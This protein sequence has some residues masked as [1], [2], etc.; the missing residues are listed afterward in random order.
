MHNFQSHKKISNHLGTDHH[1][2][3]V[4][5]DDMI[6]NIE[7]IYDIYD[8]PFGDSSFLP[9]N[10]VSKL[11]SKSVKVVL[12]GDGGDEIFLGYNR[13][14]FAKKIQKFNNYIPLRI[15]KILKYLLIN[16]SPEVCSVI[17]LIIFIN[18]VFPEPF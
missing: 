16:I 2:I 10:L 9:T 8:E 18:V 3:I 5:I 7:S 4:S 12:S 15:R 1:E 14:S 17:L 6:N 13:Y 11:A